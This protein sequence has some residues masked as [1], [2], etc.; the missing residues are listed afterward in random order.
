MKLSIYIHPES[1]NA[2]EYLAGFIKEGI[3]LS[4][5]LVIN[6]ESYSKKLREIVQERTRGHYQFR[7]LYRVLSELD[8]PCYFIRSINSKRA[9]DLIKSLDIDVLLLGGPEIVKEEVIAQPHLRIVNCH[10]SDIKKYRGCSNVEWAIYNDD[11]ILLSCHFITELVDSGPL[12]HQETFQY[13]KGMSYPELRTQII[14]AQAGT[15]I[16]GIKKLM[17]HPHSEY[18]TPPLGK[19]MDVMKEDDFKKV[20]A[21]LSDSTYSPN[22]NHGS[23]SSQ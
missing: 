13:V 4:S 6:N 10:P 23:V 3:R 17:E 12:I 5:I 21:K 2:I 18:E 22:R 20:V 1:A 7:N 19:Y 8:T 15:M 9:M 14:Y 11:E 16:N